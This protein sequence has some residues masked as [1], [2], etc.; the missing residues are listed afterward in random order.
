MRYN[1]PIVRSRAGSIGRD[2]PSRAPLRELLAPAILTLIGIAVL[3]SLGNWQVRRLAW[4]N[5]LIANAAERPKG[6]AVDLPPPAAWANLDIAENEYRPFRLTGRFLH[7]QEALV[8]TSLSDAYGQFSGPGY[9]I[10]TPFRLTDGGTVFVN[11]GFAPHGRHLPNARGEELSDAPVRVTGLL[12]PDDS[13]NLFTPDNRPADN[14]FFARDATALAA[15]KA[16]PPPVAPFTID[17]IAA[18]TPPGGLPQAGETR[19]IFTNSHLGYA[20]TWYGLA[21]ALAGVFSSFAWTRL[22]GSRSRA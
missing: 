17:L 7:D 15:A 4:K 16:I 8:F 1:T 9:W 19:M 2:G 6:A 12:R 10:V 3:V 21:A 20:I 13:P 11:R 14:M 22:A 18:E 5:E